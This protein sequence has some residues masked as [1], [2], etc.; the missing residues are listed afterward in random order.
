MNFEDYSDDNNEYA[1]TIVDE[2]QTT[3][4]VSI[5]G[6][7]SVSMIVDSGASCNVIDRQLWQSL[8]QN[9]VKCVSSSHKKQLYPYGS[10]E[11]LKTAGCFT[12]KRTVED[13]AVEAEFAVIEGKG[14]ALLGRETTTQPK[15][16]SL[17]P[18]VCVNSLQ[19]E[20]LF[21]KYKCFEGLGK[22][23]DFQLDISIHPRVKPVV[24]SM[25]RVPFSLRD[26]LEKTFDELVDR[27]VIE[28]AKGPTPRISPVVVVPK[29]DG[30]L[31]LC[32]D[33]RQAN[34]VIVRERHPIPTVDEIPH[35][36][37]GSTVFTKLDIKWAFH[38][39]ELSEESRP[40]TTFVT[41]KGLFRHKRLKFG[42]SCAP[43][44]YQR[45]MQQVL[46]GCEGV[47]NIHDDIIV[48]RK[49]AE[50]HGTRLT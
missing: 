30:D 28:K 35:G 45:V 7:P 12:A 50:Q 47:R 6:V 23:K 36:I 25:R 14:Q 32:V 11:P 13:V 26:K 5:E 43:E 15:V 42:I 49:T 34:S 40:I 29:P 38:Q 39:V 20:D 1:F 31:P 22:L 44:M 3:V 18:S 37:N 21:Q 46:E 19:G 48:H 2:N 27:D 41:H 10:K 24:Q 16:L 17:S 9:K 8:K 33:M 4:L